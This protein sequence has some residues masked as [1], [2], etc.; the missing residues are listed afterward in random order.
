MFKTK[1]RS[2]LII[3]FWQT[4]FSKLKKCWI[5]IRYFDIRNKKLRFHLV[6]KRA[7]QVQT[8]FK[9]FV[10]GQLKLFKRLNFHLS[11]RVLHLE[12]NVC[13]VTGI[14]RSFWKLLQQWSLT[15]SILKTTLTEDILVIFCKFHAIKKH[16]FVLLLTTFIYR[17]LTI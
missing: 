9:P 5:V 3:I 1:F 16:P 8:F 14:F 17:S 10:N 7:G 4:K 15:I 11:V 2:F 6:L 12:L 13:S